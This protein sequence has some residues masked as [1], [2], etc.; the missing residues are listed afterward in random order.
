M[1]ICHLS[2]TATVL[3]RLLRFRADQG[4]L[5]DYVVSWG[6]LTEEKAA[7][8]LRDVLEALH[9]LHSRRIAHLDVKVCPLT[10]HISK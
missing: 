4:R 3:T 1:S 10:L 6:N 9:Y 5:L 8:Y 7:Y 2:A